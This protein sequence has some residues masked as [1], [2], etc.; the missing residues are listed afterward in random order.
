MKFMRP[1]LL[2]AFVGVP[3][4]FLIL[5]AATYNLLVGRIDGF[6]PNGVY[7]YVLIGACVAAGVLAIGLHGTWSGTKRALVAIIYALAMTGGL[8]VLQGIVACT[9]RDCF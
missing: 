1:S 6:F 8:L 9:N 4:V 3:V 5:G 2:I 7:W